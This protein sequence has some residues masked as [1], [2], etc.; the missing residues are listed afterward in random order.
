MQNGTTAVSISGSAGKAQFGGGRYSGSLD[1]YIAAVMR[2]LAGDR[3]LAIPQPRHMVINAIPAAYTVTRAETESGI[4]DVAVVA[5]QWAPGTVY[6]FITLTSGGSGFGPFGSMVNSI[7]KIST[8]EAAA[9]RPRIIDVVTV[10]PGDSIQSLASKMA[11]RDFKLDRFLT[12]NGLNPG[13]KLAPGQKVKLIV[14]G[15]RRS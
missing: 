12:L 2:D 4:V 3:R 5:Y 14:Y 15:A 11:Y 9:I 7:R 6:H 10:A 8:A 1:S 13:A